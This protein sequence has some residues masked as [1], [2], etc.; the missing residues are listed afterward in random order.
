MM[1]AYETG[2]ETYRRVEDQVIALYKN[3]SFIRQSLT[4]HIAE[5]L[6]KWVTNDFTTP[7]AVNG[8]QMSD[9]YAHRVAPS[10]NRD[11]NLCK[12]TQPA[13]TSRSVAPAAPATTSG[14]HTP[15]HTKYWYAPQLLDFI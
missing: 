15:N 2:Q 8:P 6:P 3:R 1:Q 5:H 4:D 11:P 14:I 12:A 9:Q 7:V 10:T 13:V